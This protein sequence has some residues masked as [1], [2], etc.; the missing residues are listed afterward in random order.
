MI[1]TQ[2]HVAKHRGWQGK[3]HGV[4]H[5]IRFGLYLQAFE[6]RY[7]LQT[8]PRASCCLIKDGPVA[9]AIATGSAVS[10]GKLVPLPLGESCRVGDHEKGATEYGE[11]GDHG[12]QGNRATGPAFL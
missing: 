5:E 1:R 10:T 2:V 11:E 3:A 12:V 9:S 7:E 4:N 8:A 6:S